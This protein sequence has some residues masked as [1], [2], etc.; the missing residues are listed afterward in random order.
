[1]ASIVATVTAPN[2]KINP[3]R[4][5][6]LAVMATARVTVGMQVL[7]VMVVSVAVGRAVAVR[8][9]VDVAFTPRAAL[10]RVSGVGQPETD[11]QPAG[12]R[13]AIRFEPGQSLDADPECDT[14]SPDGH[15][16]A[17]VPHSA[18]SGDR[19]RAS[20]RPPAGTPEHDE[21]DGM[22]D[23]Y[24]GVHECETRRRAEEDSGVDAHAPAARPFVDSS[25]IEPRL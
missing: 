17:D 13:A 11:E 25:F 12:K 15:R 10:Q 1:M 24:G 18:D 21:R 5:P 6:Q 4:T 14:E 7:A 3:M 19:Q 20:Q 9:N 2:T 23:P 16:R 22:I 8:M